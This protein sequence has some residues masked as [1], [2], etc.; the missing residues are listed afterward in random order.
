MI[1]LDLLSGP[2]IPTMILHA[3]IM[4]ESVSFLESVALVRDVQQA[5][6][7]ALH[8]ESCYSCDPGTRVLLVLHPSEPCPL[9]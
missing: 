1:E 6:T 7:C 3:S 5:I 2:N 4:V 9:S 8:Y